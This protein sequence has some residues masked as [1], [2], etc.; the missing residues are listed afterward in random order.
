MFRSEKTMKLYSPGITGICTNQNNRLYS[1]MKIFLLYIMS[2]FYIAAGIYHFI[3]PGMYIK[4]MPPWLPGHAQLVFISGCCE[5]ILALLLLSE[6]TRP[7]A[8]W[9]II[10]LL[11]AVYP[12]NIQM[13]INFLQSNS[14]YTWVAAIRLPLQFLLI[15]WAWL[16][17]NH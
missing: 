4:I 14:P 15:W 1:V 9:G 11:I 6:V 17:T 2:V 13:L 12:A 5:I 3:R 16:Y 7:A 10:I 8:A